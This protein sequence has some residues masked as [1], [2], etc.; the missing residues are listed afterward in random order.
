MQ[1]LNIPVVGQSAQSPTYYENIR[2]ALIAGFFTNV[3]HFQNEG[4]H[5]GSYLTL[6]DNQQAM[7]FPGSEFFFKGCNKGAIKLIPL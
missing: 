1:K 5:K 7:K 3:A 2:K 6:K 4:K